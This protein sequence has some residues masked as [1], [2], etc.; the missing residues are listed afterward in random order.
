[1]CRDVTVAWSLSD[2]FW[3]CWTNDCSSVGC[4]RL[5]PWHLSSCIDM[6]INIIMYI[7]VLI[8]NT[9][10]Y[11]CVYL[12][13][14]IIMFV[15]IDLPCNTCTW[16]HIIKCFC[17]YVCLQRWHVC[18]FQTLKAYLLDIFETYLNLHSTYI[19][20]SKHLVAVRSMGCGSTFHD[21]RFGARASCFACWL[22]FE[23]A[24]W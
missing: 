20:R 11:V 22:Y 16:I 13:S 15:L 6:H 7:V 3:P 23:S 8:S 14:F 24:C 5:H 21:E 19:F 17:I 1:M 18:L 4:T 10:V 2:T 12:H 9:K